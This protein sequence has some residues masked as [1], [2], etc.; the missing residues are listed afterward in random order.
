LQM[1]NDFFDEMKS[2]SDRLLFL[3][4]A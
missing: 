1:V 2:H 4:A 3:E